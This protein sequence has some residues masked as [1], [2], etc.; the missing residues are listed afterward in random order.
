MQPVLPHPAEAFKARS[1]KATKRFLQTAMLFDDHATFEQESIKPTI[2]NTPILE[3][4]TDLEEELDEEVDAKPTTETNPVGALKQASEGE[5]LFAKLINE[6]FAKEGI[7]C[8]V[9]KPVREDQAAIEAIIKAAKRAD[10]VVVDWS[11]DGDQGATAMNIIENILQNDQASGSEDHQGRLRLL[12]IYTFEPDLSGV[13]EAVKSRFGFKEIG[14]QDANEKYTLTLDN[15]VRLC[16]YQKD[17]G[18]SKNYGPHKERIIKDGSLPERLIE[19]FSDMTTGLL[20]N[21][22]LT[23]LGAIRE[24]THRLLQRFSS[25]MD[26]PYFTHRVLSDPMTE[27]QEHP[28]NLLTSEIEDILLDCAVA[29][30]VDSQSIGEWLDKISAN[31]PATWS[32]VANP[33]LLQSLKDL[34]VDG[35]KKFFEAQKGTLPEPIK[36]IY[37]KLVKG[38][39]RASTMTD[40]LLGGNAKAAEDDRDF[41]VLTTFKSHYAQPAPQL[42]LGS[43]L[44]IKN[45]MN[46]WEYLVCIQPVCDATRLAPGV[47][48][49]FPFLKIIDPMREVEPKPGFNLTF[50]HRKVNR[51]LKV[52]IKPSQ[53]VLQSFESEGSHQAVVAQQIREGDNTDYWTFV[54]TSSETF[55]WLGELRFPH[56]QRVAVNLAAELSRVGLTESEW[57]RRAAK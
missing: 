7:V 46:E 3:G 30:E 49:S 19:D 50:V 16:I 6:A 27:T 22:V 48:H 39:D 29:E 42:K 21:L 8:G 24:N 36:S 38:D 4:P 5:Y 18:S 43:V 47:P 53:I 57:L 52:S 54:N 41:A 31:R 35:I 25:S 34:S 37:K 32:G 40:L 44:G 13:A 56:A 2:I 17:R 28:V 33:V 15:N 12:A 51:R 14:I 45:Q 55:E 1:I 23:A 11:I 9:I 20:F 26:A 10:I